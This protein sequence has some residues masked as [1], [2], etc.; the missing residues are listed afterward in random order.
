M[1][2]YECIV[3][4]FCVTVVGL[5]FPKA[6]WLCSAAQIAN[7]PEPYRNNRGPSCNVVFRHAPAFLM[8]YPNSILCQSEIAVFRSLH[9]HR[10]SP[11]GCPHQLAIC[12]PHEKSLRNLA[13]VTFF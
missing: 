13:L 3:I 1:Y 7:R 6:V 5:H 4:K 10:G 11:I 12:N 9:R 8:F 2:V